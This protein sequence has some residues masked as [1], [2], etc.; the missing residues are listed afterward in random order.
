MHSSND[1]T[2]KALTIWLVSSR[3]VENLSL[4]VAQAVV[5]R[6][7]DERVVTYDG[8]L[9][10]SVTYRRRQVSVTLRSQLMP[11]GQPF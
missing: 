3:S 7:W 10:V 1:W 5:V 2:T 9:L 8:A 11:N 6:G 4:S